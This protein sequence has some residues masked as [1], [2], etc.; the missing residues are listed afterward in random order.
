MEKK[1]KRTEKLFQS[2]WPAHRSYSET[3]MEEQLGMEQA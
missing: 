2:F 3:L 1:K